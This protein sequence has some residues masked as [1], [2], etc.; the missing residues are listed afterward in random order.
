MMAG[1]RSVIVFLLEQPACPRPARDEGITPLWKAVGFCLPRRGEV[2]I[3]YGVERRIILAVAPL[4]DCIARI[5]RTVIE[6][7]PD[8]AGIDD[9]PAIPQPHGAR[10]MRVPA[11]QHG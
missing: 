10:N 2:V 8:A 9:Q 6:L 4:D 11:Q 3:R 5:R 7:Q 1:W